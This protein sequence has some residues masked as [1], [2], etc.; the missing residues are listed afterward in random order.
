VK[1]S[2]IELLMEAGGFH[3]KASYHQGIR[4]GSLYT[5][6]CIEESIEGVPVYHHFV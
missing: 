1:G 6:S 4:I 3:M 2:K 5:N